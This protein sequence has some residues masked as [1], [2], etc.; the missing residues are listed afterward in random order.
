MFRALPRPFAMLLANQYV[1]K[2]HSRRDIDLPAPVYLSLLVSPSVAAYK[3]S[4]HG[5]CPRPRQRNPTCLPVG[6]RAGAGRSSASDTLQGAL[7]RVRFL[8]PSC[9]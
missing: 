7:S 9:D 3:W 4:A 5:G 1:Q 8:L 6:W 2:Q